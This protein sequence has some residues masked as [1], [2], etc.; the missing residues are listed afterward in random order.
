MR[1]FVLN[2]SGS[3]YGPVVGCSEN[4]NDLSV[5]LDGGVFLIV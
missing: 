2:L 4:S 1:R 3:F 5:S